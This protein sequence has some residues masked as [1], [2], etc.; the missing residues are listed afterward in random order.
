MSGGSDGTLLSAR[1]GPG[2]RAQA[3]TRS[4]LIE[5]AVREFGTKGPEGASTRAIATAAGTIQSSINYYFGGKQ[6]LYLAAADHIAA[7]MSHGMGSALAAEEGIGEQDAAA[8][9]AAVSRLMDRFCDEMASDGTE[10]WSLFLMREQLTPGSAFERIWTGTMG[11]FAKRLSDLIR[12]ATGMP[13]CDARFTAM[14]FLGQAHVVR[15][16]RA[17]VLRLCE[18]DALDAAT[19]CSIRTR[20]A[21]NVD[22]ILAAEH[23]RAE[24]AFVTEDPRRLSFQV[25]AGPPDHVEATSQA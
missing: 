19:L 23:T 14:T 3:D 13:A 25:D 1:Y 12:I 18:L 17:T 8:A 7:R 15:S 20:I 9:C 6:G 4:R 10:D 2:R 22:A 11:R 16:S 5:C 24:A 21:A